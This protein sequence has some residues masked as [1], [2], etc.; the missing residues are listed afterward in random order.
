MAI[1]KEKKDQKT[2]NTKK[3]DK[4][5]GFLEFDNLNF[6]LAIIQVLMYE[7]DL[8]GHQFDIYEFVE[9]NPELNIDIDSMQIVEPALDYFKDLAIPKS[10]APQVER[11]IMDG[12]NEIYGNIALCW[13]GEDGFFDLDKLSQRE[14][15]QFP[16]LKYAVLMA[17]DFGEIKGSFEALGIEVEPL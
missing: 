16:N 11:I 5:Q 8:L 4:D 9:E 2:E 6:K 1:F 13:D 3:L 17:R 15:Q 12:G 14:L 10:L 7:L